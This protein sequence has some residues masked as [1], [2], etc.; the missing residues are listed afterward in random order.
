[1]PAPNPLNVG[2]LW[3][4]VLLFK[5]NVYGAR[6]PLAVTVTDPSGAWHEPEF[7]VLLTVTFKSVEVQSTGWGS[8]LLAHPTHHMV[9]ITNK[10]ADEAKRVN[11]ILNN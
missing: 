1:L 4:D 11:L 8:S 3:N 7:V 5:A 2:E 10:K 9:A 6:P